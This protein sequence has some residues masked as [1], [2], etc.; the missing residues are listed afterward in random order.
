[1]KKKKFSQENHKQLKRYR[2]ISENAND[3]FLVINQNFRIEYINKKALKNVLGYVPQEILG[4][5]PVTFIHPDDKEKF[6]ERV[7]DNLKE[8]QGIFQVRIQKKSGEYNW[9][10]ISESLFRDSTEDVKILA[11]VRDISDQKRIQHK[12]EVAY[13]RVKFYKDLVSHDINN[14]LFNLGLAIAILKEFMR[15]KELD[16]ENLSPN[17][18]L[19]EE[20]IKKGKHLIKN[21]T[22]LSEISF[23]QRKLERVN[24]VGIL[25][26]CI[27]YIKKSYPNKNLKIEFRPKYKEVEIYADELLGTAFENLMINSIVHNINEVIKIQIT[28]KVEKKNK[29]EIVRIKIEDNGVGIPDPLKE[30]LFT[31]RTQ[32]LESKG[33]GIGLTLVYQILQKYHAVIKVKDRIKKGQVSGTKILLNFPLP[34]HYYKRKVEEIIEK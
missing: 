10:E 34:K 26:K 32:H 12:M 9:V 29:T 15:R 30:K 22:T 14:I 25:E 33:M 21:I 20:Q 6:I 4:K 27:E 13:S 3:V 24:L 1:M 16:K 31:E 18:N 17:L 23:E 28:L 7:S 19:M 5:K 11:I 8:G 2:L